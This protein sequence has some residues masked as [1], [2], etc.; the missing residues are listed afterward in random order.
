M[1]LKGRQA[2][3][4][5]WALV[6]IRQSVLQ[7]GKTSCQAEGF[8]KVRVKVSLDLECNML[9]LGRAPGFYEFLN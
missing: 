3:S 5:P 8:E 6:L 9:V 1:E 2:G 7:D 4:C